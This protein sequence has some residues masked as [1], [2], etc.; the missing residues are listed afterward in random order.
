MKHIKITVVG[1]G[2][3]GMS[4]SVLLAQKNQVTVLDIN[5]VRVKKI[6]QN[7]S[8]VK[9]DDIDSFLSNKKLNI[10]ATTD[11]GLGYSNANFIIFAIQTNYD[12]N[13]NKFDTSALDNEIEEAININP[14]ALIVIKSTV[15]IGH[16]KKLQRKYKTNR[17][18]FSPEFLREGKAL[19][20][21]LYPSRI[22]IGSCIHDSKSFVSLLQK[23]ALKENIPVL[24]IESDEA[25]AVKLFSNAYL[26][27]RIS[28]F[29]E[30]DTYAFSKKLD[31]KQIIKGICLD[32][33]IG[34]GYNNPS[35]GYGGYCLP[36]DTKQLQ[37][38]FANLPQKIIDA[39]VESNCARKDFIS[40]EIIKLNPKVV[41]FYRLIMKKGSDNYRHSSIQGV[42]KRIN[43]SGINSVIFEPLLNQDTYLGSKVINDLDHFKRHCDLI[44]TNR[45][46]EE[47]KDV[48]SK[49]L[50]RDIFQEN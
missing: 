41:G 44:V 33:R 40:D 2:Y 48:D 50:S 8:T 35:F 6:N 19:Y 45:K 43:N 29:N 16:T 47:L 25:E 14:D 31:T 30:V 46:S 12:P 21:N 38:N 24:Y 13:Q 23:S 26:A 18:V 27:M 1:S 20:D 39:I 17:I 28:F 9:D 22:I 36:K 4:L 42:L 15:P 32:G 3:V 49:C 11:K 7:K 37:A 5:T 34:D 10:S